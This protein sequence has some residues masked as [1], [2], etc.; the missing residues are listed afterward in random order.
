M[1]KSNQISNIENIKTRI[2][3]IRGIQVMLDKDLAD[4]YGVKPIRLRE[5]VKRNINRFPDDFMFRLSDNEVDFL[6]SQNAIPSKKQLGGHNPLVFTEQGVAMLS[7]VL[8]TPFAVEVSVKIMR[9][10][11]EMKKFI[12]TNAGLFQRLDKVEEK[13]MLHDKNFKQ[14]FK[15]L[16]DKNI[17]PNQGVFFNGQVFDAY[18]FVSD[19]I[20]SAKQSIILIDNYIDDTVLTHLSKRKKNVNCII[21][22]KN[23]SKQL[24]LDLEK[25]NAQYE[26]VLI[27]V[28]KE[29]HDRF[30]I[31]DEKEVYHIGASLKDLG[32]NW[33]AFSK[34]DASSVT[35]MN[36]ISGML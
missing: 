9:A 16:E 8:K 23:I 21:F 5:Q 1:T 12:T 18:I 32:K 17:K 26:P 22:T 30:L 33:F 36:T 14:L 24:K 27:K 10:F 25:Y 19:L 7:A 28:F 4:I 34:M 31:I 35:I 13:L 29:A 15:A 2:L 20:R 11:V 3:V 6:L